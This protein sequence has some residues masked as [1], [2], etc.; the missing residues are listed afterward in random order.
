MIVA[1]GDAEPLSPLPVPKQADPPP[2]AAPTTPPPVE[3]GP[4]KRRVMMRNPLGGPAGNLLADGDFEMSALPEGSFAQ[5]GWRAFDFQERNFRLETGG[6]CRTG[7][8]CG[9]L[10]RGMFLL[11]RGAAANGAGHLASVWIKPPPERG[12]DVAEVVLVACETLDTFKL[13]IPAEQPDE[14]GW[15]EL[16]ATLEEQKTGVCMF[17]SSELDGDETALID[18]AAVLPDDG[19]AMKKSASYWAPPAEMV[20]GLARAQEHIRKS[21]RFGRPAPSLP[22]KSAR[23]AS[24]DPLDGR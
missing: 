16:S 5:V 17:V 6:L 7:L 13:L 10:E 3:P 18:S 8:R 21:T 12:C 20:L 14:N 23:A 19:T 22:P 2:T 11:G 9:V 4:F 24:N 1:C 15:C